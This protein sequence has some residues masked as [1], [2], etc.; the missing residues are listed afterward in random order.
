MLLAHFFLLEAL[1]FLF[2]KQINGPY[3]ISGFVVCLF[4]GAI[5]FLVFLAQQR[6]G[7]R[8]RMMMMNQLLL[9]NLGKNDWAERDK[10]GLPL[11]LLFLVF[12]WVIVTIQ[13]L[14][15]V[16]DL[17]I[18]RSLFFE[19][20]LAKG[21]HKCRLHYVRPQYASYSP[22]LYGSSQ[23]NTHPSSSDL[24]LERH[25]PTWKKCNSSAF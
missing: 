21:S 8:W 20:D 16:C 22:T 17:W 13:G 5:K 1:V 14:C 11:M 7:R 23:L 18:G 19:L 25:C 4:H 3:D 12:E 9:L 10:D 24:E 6:W 15:C 2:L